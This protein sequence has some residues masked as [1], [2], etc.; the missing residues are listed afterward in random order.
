MAARQ[1]LSKKTRFEVFKRDLF[2]CQY[3]G[4]APPSVILEVDHLVPVAKGGGNSID[5][6]IAACFDCNRGKSDRSLDVSPETLLAKAEALQEKREQLKAYERLQKKLQRDA[7]KAVDAVQDIFQE[8][9][10]AR[11]FSA[12]FRLSIK[13]QFLSRL[14][15]TKLH[16][17]MDISVARIKAD[18]DR[19]IIYFC[20][21]CWNMIRETS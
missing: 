7:E 3:C 6:L 17:A 11:K 20:K 8:V 9:Y 21:V 4:S 19:A 2:T 16:E 18:P 10:P 14:T 12:T 15:L 13:R 1:A 5:N